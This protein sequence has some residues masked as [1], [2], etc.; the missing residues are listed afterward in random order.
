MQEG[1]AQN[2]YVWIIREK[3]SVFGRV[4]VTLYQKLTNNK[5]QK[6]LRSCCK[7]ILTIEVI[8]EFYDRALCEVMM[9]KRPR[10]RNS[11][12]GIW[13]DTC[14]LGFEASSVIGLR[15]MKIAA[16]GE[17]AAKEAQRMVSEKIEAGLILQGKALNGGLGTTALSAAAKTLDLYRQKVR[18]NQ[19]RLAK[20][21]VRRPNQPKRGSGCR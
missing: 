14:S 1:F 2:G 3:S 16:G 11:W 4:T 5:T 13:A 10:A 8:A 6:S 12:L 20:G 19:T 9:R 21:A 17:A 15:A 7:L 18:A